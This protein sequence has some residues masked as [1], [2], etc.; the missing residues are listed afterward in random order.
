MQTLKRACQLL[1]AYL[2]ASISRICSVRPSRSSLQEYP[3]FR[4]YACSERPSILPNHWA[5]VVKGLLIC[6][7]IFILLG[8]ETEC[9]FNLLRGK[10]GRQFG[11][12]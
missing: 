1:L 9:G 8:N 2:V 7:P 12:S 4:R 3:A 6:Q 10:S 5:P 11:R